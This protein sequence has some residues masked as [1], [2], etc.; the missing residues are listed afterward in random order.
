[1]ADVVFPTVF[2]RL[3]TE[4]LVLRQLATTDASALF[5]ILSDADTMTYMD[6]PPMSDV[7]EAEALIARQAEAFVAGTGVRWAITLRGDDRVIGTFS[8]FRIDRESRRA[9]VGYVLDRGHW[10][11][12]YNHEAATRVL[13]Y[14]FEELDLNR[15]E[16]ELDPE[17][18]ASAKA[19]HRLGF[20]DEGLQRE[21]WIVA[22]KVSDS[23]LV[24][25]LRAEWDTRP[26][27]ES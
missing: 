7:G 24:G 15:L 5:G 23:L 12:G 16:A 2:P 1:M 17:N 27:G 13:E 22:G 25:L 10:G 11:R 18:V 6:T 3:E 20:V 26:P 19:A 14:A 8:L 9:E 21:R 4:R